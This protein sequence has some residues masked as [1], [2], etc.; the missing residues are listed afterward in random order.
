MEALRRFDLRHLPDGGWLAGVDE[1][2]RGALAGPVVAAAVFVDRE[3]LSD[4]LCLRRWGAVN[5]SKQLSAAKRERL[6]QL[7]EAEQREGRLVARCG[8]ASVDEIAAH[9]ILGATRLAMRRAL[10]AACP[11]SRELP[12]ERPDPL[13]AGG[14]ARDLGR[15]LI[16]GKRLRPFPF[17]HDAVVKGDGKSFAIALASILAKVT[18]DHLM[19]DLDQLF[20]QYGFRLHKGYGTA[21]HREAILT[22]GPCTFH[23]ALFLRKLGASAEA[24]EEGPFE[25]ARLF[26]S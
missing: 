1:A 8:I 5:D 24:C 23:R 13:F 11:A 3:W 16:D 10:E 22:H 19:E 4:S 17:Q 20:P 26:G 12:L 6:F 9:N 2:G 15:I 21:A 25:Q 18:R 7:A 14:E